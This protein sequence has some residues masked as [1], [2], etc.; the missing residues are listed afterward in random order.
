[1]GIRR[2]LGERSAQCKQ[3]RKPWKNDEGQRESFHGWHRTEV[4]EE[5]KMRQCGLYGEKKI[6]K[7]GIILKLYIELMK[8]LENCL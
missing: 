6:A 5:G 4:S 1:M 7:I 2:G 8:K 3:I